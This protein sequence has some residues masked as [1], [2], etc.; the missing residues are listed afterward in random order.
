MSANKCHTK[1]SDK[2]V[3]QIVR[4]KCQRNMSDK[5]VSQNC[6]PYCEIALLCIFTI[7]FNFRFPGRQFQVHNDTQTLRKCMK[8]LRKCM[9]IPRFCLFR[10]TRWSR[11]SGSKNAKNVKDSHQKTLIF[12][13]FSGKRNAIF[14]FLCFS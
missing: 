11:G 6:Q 12:S 5:N 10:K 3:K 2:I 14:T 8:T 13:A 4:P 9:Y 7:V 1:M